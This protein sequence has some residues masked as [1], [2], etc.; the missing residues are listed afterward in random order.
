M[1]LSHLVDNSHIFLNLFVLPHVNI[2]VT[3]NIV[4]YDSI[5]YTYNKIILYKMFQILLNLQRSVLN[6]M[7]IKMFDKYYCFDM[8]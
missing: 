5:V 2:V 1:F 7:D 3:V 8:M 4:Y 6:I